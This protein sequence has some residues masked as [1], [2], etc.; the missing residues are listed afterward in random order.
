MKPKCAF[1]WLVC[2]GI[3]LSTAVAVRAAEAW[4]DRPLGHRNN[5]VDAWWSATWKRGDHVETVSTY[6]FN[7]KMAV[8]EDGVDRVRWWKSLKGLKA[9]LCKEELSADLHGVCKMTTD[10]IAG[11]EEPGR[12]V[13]LL[14]AYESPMSFRGIAV[15]ALTGGPALERTLRSAQVKF[16]EM[17]E[18][19]EYASLRD[20]TK[21]SVTMAVLGLLS[22]ETQGLAAMA[23]PYLK[24]RVEDGVEAAAKLGSSIIAKAR[25]ENLK[26]LC[27]DD[28]D[29]DGI[30]YCR[31]GGW[32]AWMRKSDDMDKLANLALSYNGLFNFS[33]FY[34]C[35]E[36]GQE[37]FAK[38]VREGDPAWKMI[39]RPEGIPSLSELPRLMRELP[40]D[41][42]D[43]RARHV[44]SRETIN[45]NAALFDA[46]KRDVGD[47]WSTD[48]T[49]FNGFLHQDLVGH[50]EGVVW[51]TYVGD[52]D[53][54]LRQ[55]GPEVGAK[56]FQARHLRMVRQH[57][58]FF[59][60]LRYSEEGS[61]EMAYN[62]KTGGD[63]DQAA[64]DVYV[65]KESG[66]VLKVS[67]EF[68]SVDVKA[69]PHLRLTDGFS[70]G[71][72][73]FRFSV[74]SETYPVKAIAVR[75]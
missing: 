67:M 7:G 57:K 17:L 51:M 18:D 58:G 16:A 9:K 5:K 59:T 68:R 33:T 47:T 25:E 23:L 66:Y 49:V 72:G 1:R 40:T 48:G 63:A 30:E 54:S 36:E 60:K 34:M 56:K 32:F 69:L 46:R 44:L 12:Q 39:V 11:A 27:G 71:K 8:H 45:V 19:P 38:R 41:E 64:L 28:L 24:E 42:E 15:V 62:P 2:A 35:G 31:R 50:F 22:V 29:T 26:K 61:F 37:V 4:E 65:D 43:E 13:Q 6:Q 10:V 14:R 75:K 3:G 52:E 53:I 21:K 55:F 70:S 20:R 74:Q 73:D